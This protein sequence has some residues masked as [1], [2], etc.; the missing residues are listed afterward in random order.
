VSSWLAAGAPPRVAPAPAPAGAGP[1][2]ARPLHADAPEREFLA[3][4]IALP[5]VGVELLRAIDAERDLSSPLMRRAH[6]H[7]LGHLDAPAEG[8]AGDDDELRAL[9]AELT[10]SA[11]PERVSERDLQALRVQLELQGVE[12][13]RK[14][15]PAGSKE[16][17]S[18]R[19]MELQAEFR[20]MQSSRS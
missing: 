12:R 18:R 7:L 8:I 3:D 5:R 10:L 17:Y 2:P 19:L 16:Q 11:D 6:S 1:A 13:Q 9:I 14:H 20:E 4:C 15:A